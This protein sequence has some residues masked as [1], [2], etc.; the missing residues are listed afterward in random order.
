LSCCFFFFFRPGR[1]SASP[2]RSDLQ[3]CRPAPP[4]RLQHLP[5]RASRHGTRMLGSVSSS[6]AQDRPTPSQLLPPHLA[7]RSQKMPHLL[8]RTTQR[9]TLAH[10]HLLV[11]VRTYREAYWCG[12]LPPGS[13][14]GYLRH[15]RRCPLL[16]LRIPAAVSHR[17]VWCG[18]CGR[19]AAPLCDTR[20]CSNRRRRHR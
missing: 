12:T 7:I 8:S 17:L 9:G 3:T 15:A 11:L 5:L 1:R 13:E 2:Q 6:H 19:R 4:S 18:A 16:S 10:R 14:D 20:S